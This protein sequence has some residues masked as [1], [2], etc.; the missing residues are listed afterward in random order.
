MENNN[1]Y[2][3]LKSQS[4][5]LLERY[6][7]NLQASDS[8]R[9]TIKY[10]LSGDG[11]LFRPVLVAAVAD[12]FG[13]PQKRISHIQLAVEMVHAS[14]LMHDD[15]P[16]LDNDDLRRGKPSSH[17]VFG[18][19]LTLLAGDYLLSAASKEILLMDEN[20]ETVNLIGTALNTAI[21]DMCEGQ[22]LD[23][24]IRKKEK[25]ASLDQTELVSLIQEVNLKKTGALIRFSLL[26]P[27]HLIEISQQE[28]EIIKHY[29]NNLSVL[30]QL[31]DDILD[32]K[33]DTKE[34]DYREINYV[35]VLGRQ[36]SELYAD[37]LVQDSIEALAPLGEKAEFLKYLVNYV[38]SR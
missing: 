11:K 33:H 32:S 12:V 23:L 5:F 31:C 3:D 9:K 25:K 27:L 18:E 10:S 8:L 15:L 19:G 13:I 24:E 6:L 14:S 7:S 20:S 36:K 29:A 30:F 22:V 16:A 4:I 28:T 1:K 21:C 38:R 17:K 34:G 26:A 2:N 35:D 37:S